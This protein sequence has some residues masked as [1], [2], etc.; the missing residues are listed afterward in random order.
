MKD[1]THFELKLLSHQ[2]SFIIKSVERELNTEEKDFWIKSLPEI[3]QTN[4]YLK[5][6]LTKFKWVADL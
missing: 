1:N 3:F 2:G 6:I 4:N 5:N